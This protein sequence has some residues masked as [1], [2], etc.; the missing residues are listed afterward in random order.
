MRSRKPRFSSTAI[1]GCC[2]VLTIG[3]TNLPGKSLAAASSA[4]GFDLRLG[5]S[6]EFRARIDDREQRVDLVQYVLAEAG[7]ELRQFRVDAAQ[8]FLLFFGKLGAGADEVAMSLLH[9]AKRF[10]IETVR[11]HG[12]R[13]VP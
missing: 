6:G 1:I 4:A 10:R 8:G 2:V 9:Q 7:F 13:I 11:L 3:M 12:C 5:Q